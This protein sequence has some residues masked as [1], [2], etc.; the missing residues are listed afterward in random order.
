[1]TITPE[2]AATE[3][4]IHQQIDRKDLTVLGDYA[5]YAAEQVSDE[6]LRNLLFA[7]LLID[8]RKW[9]FMMAQILGHDRLVH[10]ALDDLA[11]SLEKARAGF[12]EFAATAILQEVQP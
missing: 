1:M 6:Q 8:D 3:Q 12:M 5:A 11:H 2:Q 4:H 9:G 7:M 10:A